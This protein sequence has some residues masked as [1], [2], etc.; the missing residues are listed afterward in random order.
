MSSTA[1]NIKRSPSRTPSLGTPPQ[2]PKTASKKFIAADLSSGEPHIKQELEQ[3]ENIVFSFS[4]EGNNGRS[5]NQE[6]PGDHQSS[7]NTPPS[8][9]LPEGHTQSTIGGVPGFT[10]P[11]DIHHFFPAAPYS[12]QSPYDMLGLGAMNTIPPPNTHASA[13]SIPDPFGNTWDLG[14]H[15]GIPAESHI[16]PLTPAEI[17]QYHALL[18]RGAGNFPLHSLDAPQSTQAP[19]V[20]SSSPP[21]ATQTP[22]RGRSA[23][24]TGR[25][26]SHGL[27]SGSNITDE[28]VVAITEDK[29]RRNTAASA[30]FR[31]KKKQRT[32]ELERA[33]VELEGR[34]DELEKEA[35]E[36]RRENGWLKEMVILKGRKA[37]ENVQTAKSVTGAGP[38][39]SGIRDN[40]NDNDQEGQGTD[41]GKGKSK[42]T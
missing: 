34:A 27:P 37:M 38:S 33:L 3:W 2:T 35:V 24:S 40:A 31:V 19:E 23:S 17:A 29:R 25:S 22:T 42:E 36:L 8:H 11:W 5:S 10:T 18:A 21:P 32:I 7:G 13:H 6:Y 12:Q 28:E 30:R 39:V 41:K 15:A 16:R 20:T 26:P 1:T 14:L 9:Q 4:M